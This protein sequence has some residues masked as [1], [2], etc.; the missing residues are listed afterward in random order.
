L[1][2]WVY[3]FF[4]NHCSD[5][6]GYREPW[7]YTGDAR[8]RIIKAI[9]DRYMMIGF[10]YTQ[11]IYAH[12]TGVSPITP[13]FYEWPEIDKFHDLEHEVLLGGSLLV[14]PVSAKGATSVSVIV[15]PGRWFNFTDGKELKG[16]SEVPVTME[17]V[18]VF[19]RGGRIVPIYKKPIQSARDTVKTGLT[20]IIACDA[21]GRSEGTFYMDDG[22]T[23][24]LTRGEFIH[25]RI[26]YH[27]RSIA[28]SKIDEAEKTCPDDLANA[29]VESIQIFG[30]TTPGWDVVTGLKLRI[31]DEWV[32][33]GP[34]GIEGSNGEG[35]RSGRTA[36]IVGIVGL[37]L[38]VIG[39]AGLV[40]WRSHRK[41]IADPVAAEVDPVQYT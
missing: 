6:S 7:V 9:Y 14:V 30:E 12:S 16:D 2:S 4:R 15:P 22:I 35:K 38:G 26:T 1:G 13:L 41:P 17:D 10:W 8:R 39:V 19:I 3:P 40:L 21:E 28:W 33:T 36:L 31:R 25:R 29:V 34:K 27:N 24:N 37:C 20:L 32:Y 5:Y 23:F 18:P 11:S